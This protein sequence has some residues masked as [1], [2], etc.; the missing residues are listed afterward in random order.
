MFFPYLFLLFST[1]LIALDGLPPVSV[2]QSRLFE[3]ESL[4]S[5]AELLRTTIPERALPEFEL[6][7][8]DTAGQEFRAEAGYSLGSRR[9]A[10]IL[11][12]KNRIQAKEQS[13]HFK[14][15]K[16]QTLGKLR[17]LWI[18]LYVTQQH[19]KEMREYYS[20]VFEIWEKKAKQAQSGLGIPLDA[21]RLQIKLTLIESL[22]KDLTRKQSKAR[23][24]YAEALGKTV[25]KDLELKLEKELQLG[26]W[27]ELESLGSL[28][29]EIL[30]LMG[31]QKTLEEDL[32][33][34]ET[35]INP[36][37]SAGF[38]KEKSS[39][40][41]PVFRIGFVLPDG[42]RK[43]RGLKAIQI[44]SRMQ[45]TLG[46]QASFVESMWLLELEKMYKEAYEFTLNEVIPSAQ[47]AKKTALEAQK[48][49]VMGQ[50][51]LTDW[52]DSLDIWREMIE[53]KANQ[54]RETLNFEIQWI[55]WKGTK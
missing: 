30:S 41:D 9:R 40:A 15:L 33:K 5:Q 39:E 48:S 19:L 44:E 32:L 49:W 7:Y 14:L 45:K 51:S 52:M 11:N 18:E 22:L 29:K 17:E 31:D 24:L 35:G 34:Q 23:I 10:R 25:P 8:E 6:E 38:I 36:T 4:K 28:Q 2:T 3:I 43:D 1:S 37:V 53:T 42:M 47:Q 54:I 55:L 27:G 13:T 46:E 21:K 50:I 20:V 26:N 16:L 12:R